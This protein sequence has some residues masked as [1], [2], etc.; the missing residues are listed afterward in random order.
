MKLNRRHHV[1]TMLLGAALTFAGGAIAQD[2]RNDDR[3]RRDQKA[4]DHSRHEEKSDYHFRQA[5]FGR[6]SST[7]IGAAI[8]VRENNC[9]MITVVA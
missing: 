7:L 4:D 5:I 3:D 9:P 1:T 6:C 8:F 2:R